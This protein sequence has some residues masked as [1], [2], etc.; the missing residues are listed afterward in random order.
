MSNPYKPY[1]LKKR[2]VK[3][4]VRLMN[5]IN[6]MVIFD[7]GLTWMYTTIIQVR[8]SIK[9]VRTGKMVSTG[10]PVVFDKLTNTWELRV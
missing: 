10:T 9:G 8:E 3:K 5:K 2:G 1:K 4:S 7:G 6:Q